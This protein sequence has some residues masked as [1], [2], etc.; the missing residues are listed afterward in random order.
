MGISYFIIFYLHYFFSNNRIDCFYLLKFLNK[1]IFHLLELCII[2]TGADLE[3]QARYL[4]QQ[5]QA[6]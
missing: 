5:W 3:L 2:R 6:L 4:E 1:L